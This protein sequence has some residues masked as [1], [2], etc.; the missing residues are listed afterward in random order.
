MSSPSSTQEYDSEYNSNNTNIDDASQRLILNLT[1]GE[2]F[3]YQNDNQ[4][5]IVIKEL[6]ENQIVNNNVGTDIYMPCCHQVI[7][8]WIC[9]KHNNFLCPHLEYYVNN[10]KEHKLIK[11]NVV[12]SHWF[13]TDKIIFVPSHLIYH[14]KIHYTEISL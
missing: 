6:L 5:N 4:Y 10:R 12:D 9:K 11:R 8:H 1:T 2:F 7:L 13:R 3:T 14:V